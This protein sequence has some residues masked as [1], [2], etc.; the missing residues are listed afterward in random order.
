MLNERNRNR[1]GIFRNNIMKQAE[2]E[3]RKALEE[4]KHAVNKKK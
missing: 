2:D 4:L 3:R 1:K